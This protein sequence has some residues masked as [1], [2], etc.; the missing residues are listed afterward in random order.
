VWD[1]KK[2][3]IPQLRFKAAQNPE[4]GISLDSQPQE[5]TSRSNL[6]KKKKND[7]MQRE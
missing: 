6:K 1:G 3:R 7:K 4:V 5:K 2:L